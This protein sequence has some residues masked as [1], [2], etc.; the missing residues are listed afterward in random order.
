MSGHRIVVL[1]AMALLG[2]PG[3]A[4]A[5]ARPDSS[6]HGLCWTARPA[7]RCPRLPAT[8]E[9]ASTWMLRLCKRPVCTAQGL[10]WASS[11]FLDLWLLCAA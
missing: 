5:Q 9:E 7:P 11:C 3:G 6:H 10:V 2:A 4:R 1:A 8:K